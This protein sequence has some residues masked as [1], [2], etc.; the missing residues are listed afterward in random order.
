MTYTVIVSVSAEA[1][2]IAIFD[3]IAARAGDEIAGRFV[4]RIESYVLG[5]ANTPSTAAPIAT[6]DRA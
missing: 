1:D 2:L 3:Y 5:F 6:V 4:D